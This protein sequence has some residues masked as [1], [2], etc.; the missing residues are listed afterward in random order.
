M[1][2]ALLGGV[3]VALALLAA[4][5]GSG[6]RSTAAGAPRPPGT[7]AADAELLRGRRIFVDR[8]SGCHG[9][10]GGGNVGPSFTDGKLLRDFASVDEQVAFVKTGRG[11][12][13]GFGSLLGDDEIRAVV[14]YEREVLSRPGRR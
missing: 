6:G 11:V 9:I 13:P 2:G 5:C 1:R 12:M 14:R 10:D 3:T 8:C 4:A 7:L